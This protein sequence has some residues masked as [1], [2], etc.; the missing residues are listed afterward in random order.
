[1]KFTSEHVPSLF[2]PIYLEDTIKQHEVMR[3]ACS[4]NVE[5]GK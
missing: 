2:D 3:Y 4:T 1:M 5:L